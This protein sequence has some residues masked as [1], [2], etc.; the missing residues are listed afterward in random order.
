MAQPEDLQ[1]RADRIAWFHS[2]DLG[3][4]VRTRGLSLGTLTE[5]QLPNFK[6]HTTLDIGAWDGKYSFVAEREGAT[7]VVALDHY[8]WGVDI[9][10]RDEYWADCRAAGVLPD[11]KK[12]LAE[13]WRPDLPGQAGFNFAKEALGSHVQPLVADFMTMDLE[14]L[15][16]FDVVLYLG[17]LYHI[18][19]PLTALERV[20]RVTKELAVIETE[21]VSIEGLERMPLVAFFASSDV[22]SDFGNW[23]VPT[24]PAL[25]AL[26][27]AAGF[28]EVRTVSGPKGPARAGHARASHYRALVY[29]YV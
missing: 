26:C 1:A 2:I 12:D 22:N 29:A 14:S 28:T 21:A 4:G 16:T 23:Y 25:H 15:G 20:R 5:D 9:A 3:D 11:H 19:E 18:K 24:L 7:R 17:V 10:A 27:K 6:G 13:F 8:V